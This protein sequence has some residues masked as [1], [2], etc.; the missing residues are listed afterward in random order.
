MPTLFAKHLVALAALLATPVTALHAQGIAPAALGPSQ[1]SQEIDPAIAQVIAS[2]PAFDNHAHPVL[3][4]SVDPADR[5]FDALPVDNMEPQTDPI[6][7][8][9]DNPALRA[10]WKALWQVDIVPPAGPEAMQKL[11]TARATVQAREVANYSVWVLDQAGIGT[12]VANRVAL[13]TGIAAPRFRWVPYADAL[14]FP[15]NNSAL[16]AQTPDKANFFAL[17]DKLRA[18]YLKE[19]GLQQMPRTLSAYL[20]NVITPTVERQ[21][22]AGAIAEKFELAYLRTLAIGNPSEADASRIYA[23]SVAGTAPSDADYKLL[24]DFLF[25]YIAQECGRLGMAVHIHVMEG[26]GSYFA[27][28]GANA[29][30]L[31]PLFN[32]PRL[33]KTRFVMLHG[34]WPFVREALS[35]L[36]KPN[37]YLDISQ[38]DYLFSP[39]VEA[40]WLRERLEIYPD[41]VLFGTDGYPYSDYLGWEEAAWIA[42]RNARTALGLALTAMLRDGEIDEARAAVLARMVLRDNAL[43]LYGK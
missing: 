2:T 10:A 12:M 31:E 41:K 25:R 37:V 33:R 20:A 1:L 38:E 9:A 19:A 5:G 39:R 36:E 17:E 13:G 32:D 15:L 14:V 40:A 24:Q 29:M 3:P 27:I 26:G 18:R 43:A 28:A 8:R 34:G 22:A 4:P 6:A 35:L 11:K 7:L 21:H 42:A 16:A 23:Q 30:N